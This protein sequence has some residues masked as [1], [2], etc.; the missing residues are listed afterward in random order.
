MRRRGARGS[1]NGPLAIAPD[2]PLSLST[3]YLGDYWTIPSIPRASNF[4]RRIVAVPIVGCVPPDMTPPRPVQKTVPYEEDEEAI[5]ELLESGPALTGADP[6]GEPIPPQ[7][8]RFETSR[9]LLELR[10]Q[11]AAPRT[12]LLPSMDLYHRENGDKGQSGAPSST[13]AQ[14]SI[15]DTLPPLESVPP[16]AP[17]PAEAPPARP[18]V[19]PPVRQ[20]RSD[21]PPPLYASPLRQ[22]NPPPAHSSSA[23]PPPV[24]SGRGRQVSSEQLARSLALTEPH[25]HTPRNLSPEARRREAETIP[26]NAGS[27]SYDGMQPIPSLRIPTFSPKE[28]GIPATGEPA[29][30]TL[31][32]WRIGSVAFVL[33]VSLLVVAGAITGINYAARGR[34][35]TASVQ[36]KA[37]LKSPQPQVRLERLTPNAVIAAGA[38]TFPIQS[39]EPPETADSKLEATT[40]H[41][42]ARASKGSG[43]PSAK[44]SAPA[45]VGAKDSQTSARSPSTAKRPA[46]RRSKDPNLVDTE[47]PLISN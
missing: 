47:T 19:V 14:K 34:G 8:K 46:A 2:R 18:S 4:R 42:V 7:S 31:E 6:S 28:F 33:L 9:D 11:F 26:A 20:P 1:N 23:P 40:A 36:P 22:S 32:N 27:P 21:A 17:F 41:S 38:A 39:G 25:P 45:D 10:K 3:E 12:P 13:G 24:S 5:R 37:V 35:E 30:R 43:S 44:A 16:P 29:I 15:V